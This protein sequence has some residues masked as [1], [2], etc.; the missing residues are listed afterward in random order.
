MK[1][2]NWR[3]LPVIRSLFKPVTEKRWGIAAVSLCLGILLLLILLVYTVDPY[4]HY[5]KPA[6]YK[7]MFRECYAIAPGMMRHFDF[8]CLMIGSS[9]VRN[10]ALPDINEYLGSQQSIKISASSATSQDLK[11]ITDI[12]FQEKGRNLKMVVYA[13]DLWAVNKPEPN[14]TMFDYLYREDNREDYKYFF[15][16]KTYSAIHQLLKQVITSKPKKARIHYR[17]YDTMFCTD[18]P[19]KPYGKLRVIADALDCETTKRLPQMPDQDTDTVK[20][21]EEDI[22]A[23]I[24][25]HP[26]TEF[27]I[28]LPPTS[29]YYWCLVNNNE[30]TDKNGTAKNCMDALLKQKKMML[31]R[32]LDYPNVRVYDPHCEETFVRD[33]ARYNDTTH[34]SAE[35]CK[36]ILAGIGQD[37]WRIR[38]LTDIERNE[39][40]LRALVDSEMPHYLQDIENMKMGK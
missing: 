3:D 8:D 11:K 20:R 36:E 6:W 1:I 24:E 35:I 19:G 34:Y 5:R 18:Y 37:K 26:E 15:S 14:Y 16:R 4:M 32:L 9:M 38:T 39:E 22:L 7:P 30:F 12:A 23:L 2:P 40:K 25:E 13:M 31:L 33:Y 17:N 29:L 27:V 21:F 28:F 10:F